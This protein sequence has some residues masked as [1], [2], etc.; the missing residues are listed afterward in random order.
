MSGGHAH[1]LYVHAH[2]RVHALP[3]QCKIVATV[4]F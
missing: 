3:P 1:G 2:S 4:L